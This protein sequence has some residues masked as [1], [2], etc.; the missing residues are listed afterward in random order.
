[1]NSRSGRSGV[2]E[3]RRNAPRFAGVGKHLTRYAPDQERPASTSQLTR[4]TQEHSRESYDDVPA[5]QNAAYLEEVNSAPEPVATPVAEPAT[6]APSPHQALPKTEVVQPEKA[7]PLRSTQADLYS[8]API[9]ISVLKRALPQRFADVEAG[10]TADF[11]APAKQV[12]QLGL[13][14]AIRPLKSLFP[15]DPT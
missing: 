3:R 2:S 12:V 4:F 15:H 9:T 11:N 1:M 8:D 6:P 13:T 10:K 14:H 5:D 7:Q